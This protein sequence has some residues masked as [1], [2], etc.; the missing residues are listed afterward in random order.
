[1]TLVWKRAQ[2]GLTTDLSNLDRLTEEH[3]REQDLLKREAELKLKERDLAEQEEEQQHRAM[4]LSA[5]QRD[6][7]ARE[8]SQGGKRRKRR[9]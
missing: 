8:A 6:L 3:A 1:L 9:E 4:R 2:Q 7:E 5:W